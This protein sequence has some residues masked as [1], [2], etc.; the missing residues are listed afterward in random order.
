M[1]ATKLHV[2]SRVRAAR[3]RR[4]AWHAGIPSAPHERL[5]DS[6]AGGPAQPGTA[7]PGA[8]HTPLR[9]SGADVL[10]LGNA[11]FGFLAVCRLAGAAI[12]SGGTGTGL[13]RRDLAGVVVLLL[14]AAACDLLDGQVARRFGGSRLGAELD[15]LADVISFGFAPAFFVVTWGTFTRDGDRTLVFAAALAILVAVLV[16]LARF[17]NTPHGDG[18]FVGLPCPFGAMSVLTLVLLNPPTLLGVLAVAAVAYL[19]VSRISYPKPSGRTANVVLAWIGT[20]IC[21]TAGW[22]LNVPGGDWLLAA[23]A[24]PLLS[25]AVTVPLYVA[26]THHRHA[27]SPARF[28]GRS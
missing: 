22:A 19:M 11:V 3:A 13:T 18:R 24:V 16:R 17:A 27:Y 21:C 8:G 25:A 6:G 4:A 2:A 15:N 7:R 5:G 14:A 10:T 1:T 9:L 12:T 28:F 20:G 26:M 23:G